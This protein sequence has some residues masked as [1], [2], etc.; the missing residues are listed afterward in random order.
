MT[1]LESF[2]RQLEALTALA[3]LELSPAAVF[4]LGG[5]YTRTGVEVQSL[6]SFVD[7]VQ[8]AVN[9]GELTAQELL[10]V[11]FEIFTGALGSAREG[12]QEAAAKKRE[13]R[14]CLCANDT[15]PETL[16]AVSRWCAHK[17]HQDCARQAI[18]QA[19]AHCEGQE[20]TCPVPNCTTQL[21]QDELLALFSSDQYEEVLQLLSRPKPELQVHCPSFHCRSQA[22]WSQGQ[23]FSCETCHHTYCLHCLSVFTASDPSHECK[24]YDEECLSIGELFAKGR[25]FKVCEKCLYWCDLTGGKV[26]VCRCGVEICTVCEA[27]KKDCRCLPS[28]VKRPIEWL[29][30]LLM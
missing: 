9:A 2:T 17:C 14:C 26:V 6:L 20:L 18:C 19:I 29:G 25:K 24:P 22:S 8:T 13:N 4:A 1:D 23:F 21:T 11:Q 10:Q 30:S 3:G 27:T 28:L 15:T 12:V 5:C 7:E 16:C